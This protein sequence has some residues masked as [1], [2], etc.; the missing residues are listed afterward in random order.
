MAVCFF[1]DG[2]ASTTDFHSGLNFAATLGCPVIFFCRNNGYAISTK[3]SEQYSGDGIVSRSTGYG[4]AGIRVDG[5]DIFAVHAA[6]REAR[7]YALENSAPVLI[8]AM[9]Y[10]VG[11]HS[12]SDDSLRYRSSEEVQSFK[13]LSDPVSR[14]QAFLQTNEMV[15]DQDVADMRDQERMAVIEAMRQ[16]E[17]K[18][19]PSLDH[20]FSDVYHSVP[21]SLQRQEEGLR[22]HRS[23]HPS[24]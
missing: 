23:K 17:E 3:V 11:H 6:V 1:G 21:R 4:M 10:R 8:E 15:S 22:L 2:C 16:A 14:L 19:K 20:M 7:A 18:A 24:Y 12:T 5:N 9:T 13:T